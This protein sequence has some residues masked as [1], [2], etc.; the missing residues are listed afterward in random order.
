VASVARPALARRYPAK[1]RPAKPAAIRASPAIAQALHGH[2]F[3]FDAAGVAPDRRSYMS[4]RAIIQVGRSARENVSWQSQWPAPLHSCDN[5][6]LTHLPLQIGLARSFRIWKPCAP[7]TVRVLDAD[8]RE[9]HSAVRT[10]S[11]AGGAR[12]LLLRPYNR[13]RRASPRA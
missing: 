10:R 2:E 8:G 9:V 3:R 7:F 11:R 4:A 1:P 5:R 12:V 13:P 6:P